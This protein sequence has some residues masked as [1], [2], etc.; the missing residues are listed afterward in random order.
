MADRKR[1]G[2]PGTWEGFEITR[3]RLPLKIAAEI[4]KIRDQFDDPEDALE[5]ILGSLDR[6]PKMQRLKFYDF[7]VSA[8]PGITGQSETGSYEE[9]DV[10]LLFLKNPEKCFLARVAGDSMKDA[11]ITN[12]A[13]IVVEAMN[14]LFQ[15]PPNHSIVTAV[16]EGDQVVIKR[17]QQ[18]QNHHELLSENSKRKYPPI[19]ISSEM[20]EHQSAYIFGIYQRVIPESLIDYVSF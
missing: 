20:S 12:G 5:F 18:R 16:V 8:T 15:A 10:P 14:P 9:R 11:G 13:F 19:L 1:K 6:K 17:Y 2:R 7:R 3:P 4:D